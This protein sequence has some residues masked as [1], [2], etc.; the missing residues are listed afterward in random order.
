MGRWALPPALWVT[1][2]NGLAAERSPGSWCSTPPPPSF[3]QWVVSYIPGRGNEMGFK[4]LSALTHALLTVGE[5]DAR[6]P[7]RTSVLFFGVT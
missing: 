4:I 5:P 7:S 1:Q 3:M 2:G 6:I